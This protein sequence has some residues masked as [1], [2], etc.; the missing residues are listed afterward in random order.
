[1]KTMHLGFKHTP[2]VNP[3]ID[4]G[5]VTYCPTFQSDAVGF[6]MFQSPHCHFCKTIIPTFKTVCAQS[7]VP[8]LVLDATKTQTTLINDTN[9]TMFIDRV[10]CIVAFAYGMPKHRV[11]GN[12][13][14]EIRQFMVACIATY[15]TGEQT[16]SGN[17]LS[18]ELRRQLNTFNIGE[19]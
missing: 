14:A 9:K 13:E 11:F 12:D 2:I 4:A 19:A 17:Y 15:R 1:M 10:P 3:F 5:D 7:A 6:V 8:H 18:T 16:F